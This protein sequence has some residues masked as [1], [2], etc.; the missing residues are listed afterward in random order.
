M[1]KIRTAA[2][3]KCGGQTSPLTRSQALANNKSPVSGNPSFLVT[4]NNFRKL[5]QHVKSPSKLRAGSLS[6]AKTEINRVQSL[7]QK[8]LTRITQNEDS[9]SKVPSSVLIVDV[10]DYL[11]SSSDFSPSTTRAFSDDVC[12]LSCPAS[13]A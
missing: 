5:E 10:D 9:N 8:V 3:E 1:E 11:S 6:L 13:F 2:R 12:N 4:L 7:R